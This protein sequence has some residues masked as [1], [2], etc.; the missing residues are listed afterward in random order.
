MGAA[1]ERPKPS[2]E[3]Q[4]LIDGAQAAPSELGA[5]ILLRV[6]D[7]GVVPS[8]EQR[9]EIIEQAFQIAG[10]AKFPY[11]LTA[12]VSAALHTD[13]SAGIRW[14]ATE[15]LS[16]LA[17]RS[18][19]VRAAMAFE[20]AAALELFWQISL[21][22]F[23][24]LTCD[25]ALAPSFTVYY[26]T[27]R[28]VATNA[29]GPE[30]R[31]EGRHLELIE[32]AVR[33]IATARQLEPAARLLAAFPLPSD[34]RQEFANAY[35]IALGQIHADPRTFGALT[36]GFG[37][38][39]VYLASKLRGE[40]HSM[41]PLV[42]AFGAYLT[43]HL[44]GPQCAET[45]DPEKGG[46]RMRQAVESLFN[47][48]LLE[49][50]G[51]TEIEPLDFDKLK[52]KSVAGRAKFSDYWQE[53]RSREIMAQYKALR[54][55]TKEQQEE[56][57]KRERR[58]DGMAHFLPDELRRTPEWETQARQ[59]LNELDR[60]SRNHEE[61]EDDLFHQMCLQFAA[62]LNIIPPGPLHDSVLQSYISFLKTSPMQ[63]ESPPEWLVH[64]KR[65]FRIT[66]AGPEQLEHLRAEVRR[67]G[68]LA[69]SLYAELA[70]LEALRQKP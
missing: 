63:H 14:T 44:Q 12:A 66:D 24:A 43:R 23:L 29:F 16:T 6:V 20:K 9:L 37:Q 69:M 34:R 3:I 61:P 10:Q 18:R 42:G 33:S 38:S 5:D 1:A 17:L 40:G 19:A 27:L 28:E 52:P 21:G 70:R 59:F 7:L 67:S 11:P 58:K 32:A 31:K 55:G 64:V 60:W 46:S 54:F 22:P 56:Y 51:A 13:S 57:N 45:A 26:E 39:V 25:D 49:Q 8:S 35:A 48:A 62:L 53:G 36:F 68:S 47:K 30:D 65:L 4:A 15:G 2:P 50:S 41:V